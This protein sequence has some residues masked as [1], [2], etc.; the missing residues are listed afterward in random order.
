MNTL[1]QIISEHPFFQG[2]SPE[3]LELVVGCALNRRL[4]KDEP[5]LEL[6]ADANQFWLIRQGEVAVEVPHNGRAVTVQTLDDGD[7]LG[8]SW[9]VPPYKWHFN[10]RAT[11]LTRVIEFDARCLREK[12]EANHDLGY[13]IV[14]RLSQVASE[15]LDALRLQLLDVYAG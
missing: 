1:E 13:I 2:L 15:L 8:W 4:E 3:H 6:G 14:N 10:A 11:R 7:V 5:L 9:M 12:C